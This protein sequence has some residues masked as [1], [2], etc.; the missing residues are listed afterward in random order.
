VGCTNRVLVLLTEMYGLSDHDLMFSKEDEEMEGDENTEYLNARQV[1]L[2]STINVVHLLLVHLLL[3][4]LLLVHLLLARLLL[5]R[6]L[7]VHL[8]LVHLLLVH[9]LLVSLLL[10]HLLLVHLLLVLCLL[11]QSNEGCRAAQQ[12]SPVTE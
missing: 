8:L 12:G 5:A 10:V 4:H 6:L 2:Q 11:F 7:L 9:L 1:S 3:V